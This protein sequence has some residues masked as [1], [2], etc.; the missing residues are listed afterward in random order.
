MVNK[1]LL[2]INQVY[3]KAFFFY[4]ESV[5][6][7]VYSPTH[8][9]AEQNEAVTITLN[10]EEEDIYSE[11]LK[12]SKQAEPTDKEPQYST[13]INVTTPQYSVPTSAPIM[14][15]NTPVSTKTIKESQYST[16]VSRENTLTRT[17]QY[18]APGSTLPRG[19]PD[20]ETHYNTPV[21]NLGAAKETTQSAK[22]LQV[23][24]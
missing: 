16:P 1:Y 8:T 18:S 6:P 9:D 10:Q 14:H 11:T 7:T 21:T 13:P 24:I 22:N 23:A 2:Y 5:R 12:K 19:Q 17:P 4:S 3:L 20:E 15:Y